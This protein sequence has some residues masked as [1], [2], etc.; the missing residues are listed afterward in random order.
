[1]CNMQGLEKALEESIRNI[2]I[3]VILVLLF[4]SYF[5]VDKY[6]FILLVSSF[7]FLYVL[8]PIVKKYKKVRNIHIKHKVQKETW[9]I[10]N[11]Y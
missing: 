1:M 9:R 7:V 10:K 8:V 4:T 11:G 3:F 6:S 2:C 5:F